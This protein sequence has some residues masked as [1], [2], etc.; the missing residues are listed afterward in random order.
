MVGCTTTVMFRRDDTRAH[1]AC[2]IPHTLLRRH[3]HTIFEL[4]PSLEYLDIVE[5]Y[6]DSRWRVPGGQGHEPER[7]NFIVTTNFLKRLTRSSATSTTVDNWNFLPKLNELCLDICSKDLE[8]EA[9]LTAI[10]SRTPSFT[11]VLEGLNSLCAFH[12]HLRSCA[13][14]AQSKI[15]S[16]MEGLAEDHFSVQIVCHEPV[17]SVIGGHIS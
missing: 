4:T 15:R 9:L 10:H 13:P 14:E 2:T 5:S 11:A 6:D 17:T 1:K 12:M 7:A 8:D 16:L 3:I